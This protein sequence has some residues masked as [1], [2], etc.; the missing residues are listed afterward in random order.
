MRR[1][2]EIFRLLAVKKDPL[3]LIDADPAALVSANDPGPLE[4]Q[5]F[6]FNFVAA[7]QAVDT[8]NASMSF[9]NA[10]LLDEE[11]QPV[12]TA[13]NPGISVTASG[14]KQ[15]FGVPLN[16]EITLSDENRDSAFADGGLGVGKLITGPF[17]PNAPTLRPDVQPQETITL[18]FDREVTLDLITLNNRD[19]VPLFLRGGT[20]EVSVDGGEF[21]SFAIKHF[22]SEVAGLVG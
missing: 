13:F 5:L 4:E 15:I 1:W 21:Q 8:S 17:F 7:S 19:Q 11:K 20:F 3:P 2:D 22:L 12:A 6:S 14:K 18:D 9:E 10:R 16:A